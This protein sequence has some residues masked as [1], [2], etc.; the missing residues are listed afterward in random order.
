MLRHRALV[1]LSLVTA[2]LLLVP[3]AASAD[4]AVSIT[5]DGID[6]D[7]V[8]AGIDEPI[9]FTNTTD[10]EVRLVDDAGRWDSG[11]LVPNGTFTITFSGVITSTF[12]SPDG[13][14]TGTIEIVPSDEAR[15]EEPSEEPADE[16]SAE[17]ASQEGSEEP[18]DEATGDEATE[19]ASDEGADDEQG[20]TGLADTGAP[21]AALAGLVGMSLLIGAGLL[22]RT[23]RS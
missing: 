23:R 22:A 1:L 6:P 12:T 11:D 3:T 5:D 18:T 21:V 10:G 9:V 7:P 20:P 17:P 15:S 14:I 19:E 8:V 4:V 2:A 13:A 16:P